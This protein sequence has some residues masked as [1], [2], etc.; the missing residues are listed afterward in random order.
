V[1]E[2]P[3]LPAENSNEGINKIFFMDVLDSLS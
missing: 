3:I 2:L 1:G